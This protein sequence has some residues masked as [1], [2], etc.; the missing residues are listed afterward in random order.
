VGLIASL[1]VLAAQPG[2]EALRV[3]GNTSTIE[4][5]PV[6]LA[7]ERIHAAPVRIVNGGVP[8]LFKPNAAELATN[9]ETQALRASVDNPG[10][11]IIL[12]VSEG[13]Y[14]I[15]GRRSAGIK[16]LADLKG[17]RIATFPNTSS[18]YYLT[19]MLATV[20]L[21][22]ADVTIVPVTP[23]SSLAEKLQQHEVDAVT[24]WE[25]E[26]QNAAERLGADAIEFQDR[27]V[28]R[29]LFNLHATAAELADPAQRKRIVAFVRSVMVATKQLHQ[30]PTQA[31]SL[32]AT[33]SHFDAD[34][35]AR[36]WH[37]EGYP[38]ALVPDLLDVLEAEELYVAR[39]RNRM[40]R[41]RAELASLID[42]SVVKEVLAAEPALR[43]TA[44]TPQ[45]VLAQTQKLRARRP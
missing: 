13:Y 28:Y 31:W 30:D 11:R 4:L 21:S 12:T 36:V 17:K 7:A 15:V 40:P 25:P 5:A 37:H 27:K 20:G 9:A 1:P 24:I 42:D 26:I 32:V 45:Q 34:L 6:L 33:S 14:R 3:Y 18:A 29:E 39:E 2:P 8:D 35:I 43:V 16:S 44:P 41:T 10:L 23:L 38:G 22:E 19:R